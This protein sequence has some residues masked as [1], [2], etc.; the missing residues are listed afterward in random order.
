M[1]RTEVHGETVEITPMRSNVAN[2]PSPAGWGARGPTF[3]PLPR[4]LSGKWICNACQHGAQVRRAS[5]PHPAEQS[6]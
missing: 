1:A 2:A 4:S 3:S 6:A 5:L